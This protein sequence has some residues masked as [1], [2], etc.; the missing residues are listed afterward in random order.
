[1]NIFSPLNRILGI[2]LNTKKGSPIICK[3]CGTPLGLQFGFCNNCETKFINY[4][5]ERQIKIIEKAKRA[6]KTDPT[7]N[8]LTQCARCHKPE[9]ISNRPL[10]TEFCTECE[11]KRLMTNGSQ[12]S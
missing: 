3:E 11:K 4:S 2:I 6:I 7:F 9:D 12:A 8:P 5:R 10:Y 1:M